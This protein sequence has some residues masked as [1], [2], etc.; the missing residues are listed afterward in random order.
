MDFWKPAKKSDKERGVVLK[1]VME[2]VRGGQ[3]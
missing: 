2:P 1:L 3:T